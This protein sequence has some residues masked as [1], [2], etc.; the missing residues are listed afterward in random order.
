MGWAC[1]FTGLVSWAGRG[2]AGYPGAEVSPPQ[3]DFGPGWSLRD[4]GPQVFWDD[5]GKL[6]W[7]LK[8]IPLFNCYHHY[9]QLPLSNNSTL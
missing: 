4:Y 1:L 2:L 8:T 7:G 5:L 6:R 3:G 9:C